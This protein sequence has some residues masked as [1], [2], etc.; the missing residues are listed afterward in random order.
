MQ[1]FSKL[2]LAEQHQNAHGGRIWSYEAYSEGRRRFMVA[3][4][5][6]L[7]ANYMANPDKIGDEVYYS[8]QPIR[9]FYDLDSKTGT[10]EQ[11][12]EW[13]TLLTDATRALIGEETSVIVLRASRPDKQSAHLI[14][15]HVCH[16]IAE[17]MEIAIKIKEQ[18]PSIP[19]DLV[20]YN[21]SRGNFRLPL[22]RKRAYKA[23]LLSDEPFD[24]T[25]ALLLPITDKPVEYVHPDRKEAHTGNPRWT[26]LLDMMVNPTWISATDTTLRCAVRMECMKQG[27]SC[28]VPR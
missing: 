25:K 2:D 11:L 19:I 12:N 15:D 14:F 10:P 27:R 17:V 21:P 7:I 3:P 5:E 24:F 20:P 16:T 9:V 4:I 28:P 23:Y 18:H 8:N 6:T 26:P 1:E 13:I 22:A